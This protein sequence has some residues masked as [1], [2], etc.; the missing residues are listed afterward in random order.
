VSRSVKGCQSGRTQHG[1]PASWAASPEGGIGRGPGNSPPDGPPPASRS[2]RSDDADWSG[3]KRSA[4][5]ASPRVTGTLGARAACR[6]LGR[7]SGHPW[8]SGRGSP[9][10]FPGRGASAGR[11]R[12]GAP[13]GVWCRRLGVAPERETKSETRGTATGHRKQHGKIPRKGAILT[14]GETIVS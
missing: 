3:P 5:A 9:K 12:L 7:P 14:E 6:L 2:S 11:R 8:V 10:A 1:S 4:P 13:I